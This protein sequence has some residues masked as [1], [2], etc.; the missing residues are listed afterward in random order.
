MKSAEVLKEYLQETWDFFLR[1]YK[2]LLVVTAMSVLTALICRNPFQNRVPGYSVGDIARKDIRAP[3]FIRVVDEELTEKRRASA[4]ELVLPVY[5]F[6]PQAKELVVD[7]LFK[8]LDLISDQSSQKSEKFKSSFEESL[9]FSLSPSQWKFVREPVHREP[10]K[11]LLRKIVKEYA[12]IWLLDENALPNRPEIILRDIRTSEEFRVSQKAFQKKMTPIAEARDNIRSAEQ[13]HKKDFGTLPASQWKEALLI[14]SNLLESDLVFNDIETKTRQDEAR[15]NVEPIWAETAK[16]E[17]IVREGQRVDR[18]NFLLLQGLRETQK[19][20]VEATSTILFGVLIFALIFLFYFLGRSNFKK[21]RFSFRDQWVLGSFF[22]ISLAL[23]GGL[24]HLF[25]AAR[26]QTV[27]GPSLPFLL[28][29]AFAGM[30]VRLFSSME[31][32]TF[33]II[34]FSLAMGWMMESPFSGLLILGS[35]LAGAGRMRHI[36]QRLDVFKAGFLSGLVKA[37]LATVGLGL[38]M[39][40]NPGF[41]TPLVNVIIIISFCILSGLIS[42]TIIL[43]VQPLLEYVG[44]T[45]D[46]RL[47]EL[48]STDHPLLKDLIMKAPGTYFHSFTV[49]QLAEKA[50]ESIHA[51][52]LFVRVASLYHDIG[53]VK[54]P[55]YFIENIKGENKHDK[56]VPTMSALIISNHVKDGIELAEEHN[57]PQAIIEVIPQHHGTALISYFFDKAK[58]NLSASEEINDRDFRYP[59]PKPQTRESAI[60]LLADAVE[61]TAKSLQTKSADVLSQMVHQTIQRFFLDGQLD[62]CELTLKDLNAIGNAFLQVLQGVYHQRIDY[63]H[64]KEGQHADGERASPVTKIKPSASEK[65]SS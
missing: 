29:V 52:A 45:T 4:A 38:A 21:F 39:V 23:M 35:A 5:D 22:V 13:M 55:Q 20:R 17:V 34:L 14:V 61:A 7:R 53:K 49:S 6:D 12:N 47:M 30:T 28:P 37:G 56:L 18:R 40:D 1:Y 63:P 46:L 25:F 48:S 3:E 58:K 2:T 59:G 10:L 26:E 11:R 33:F 44:Y 27:I 15:A 36:T 8:S 9:G 42:S 43:G 50:A 19:G 57:L 64:L 31:I 41:E 62:E 51:N 16:G 54:K 32:T 65:L 24:S 60:V